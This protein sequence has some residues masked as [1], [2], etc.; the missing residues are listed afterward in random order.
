MQTS[1]L[2]QMGLDDLKK[3]IA[4]AIADAAKSKKM[5]LIGPI[6]NRLKYLTSSQAAEMIGVQPGT[7]RDWEKDGV[8]RAHKTGRNERYLLTEVLEIAADRADRRTRF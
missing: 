1:T 3:A 2:I 4:D 8:I 6:L 7:I 5:E